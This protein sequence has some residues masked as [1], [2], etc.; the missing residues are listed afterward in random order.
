MGNVY[1]D[2]ENP[3]ASENRRKWRERRETHMTKINTFWR[4]NIYFA[5]GRALGQFQNSINNKIC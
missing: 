3:V 2:V 4:E 1:Q 5:F